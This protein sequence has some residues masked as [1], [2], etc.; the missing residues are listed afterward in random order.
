MGIV[1]EGWAFG[2]RVVH[3]IAISKKGLW[4]K[5][6]FEKLAIFGQC[7]PKA[8]IKDDSEISRSWDFVLLKRVWPT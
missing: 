8:L 1:L 4:L 2:S 5:G 6:V 3:A 7:A